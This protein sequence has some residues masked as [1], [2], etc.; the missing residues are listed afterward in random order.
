[1]VL[2][3]FEKN[4]QKYA[5]LLAV[6]GINVQP[7]DWVKMTITVDQAPL[8]R[9]ITEEAYK[10]GAEKVV[11]KWSDDAIGKMHYQ[12]QPTE[13]LT[14][15]PKY[16]IEEVE[17][18]ILNHRVSRL[19]IVSSD[20]GLLNDIDPEKITAYQKAAS[21][22]FKTQ[23]TATQN[24]EVK[25]TVAAAAGAGWAAKVF[26]DLATTEEQVDALWD[27][28]FKTCRVYEDDPITAWDQHVETLKKKQIN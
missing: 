28:I 1:M 10:L 9:L 23:L 14:D 27:Q 17:D 22:A 7:G 24:D 12:H 8:A 19:S 26:P 20:P 5:K 6:K 4:L 11:V 3:N 18:H 21:K 15:I 13:V 16:E 25:W 2:P